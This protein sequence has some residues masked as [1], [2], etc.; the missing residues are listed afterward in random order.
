MQVLLQIDYK[1]YEI[2]HHL[3]ISFKISSKDL[4]I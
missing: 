1:L 4:Q 2:K 3:I